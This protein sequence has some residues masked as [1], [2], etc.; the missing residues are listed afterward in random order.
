[1]A[2]SEHV[3]AICCRPEV[4]G[5]VVSGENVKTIEGYAVLDFEF[6]SFESFRDIPPKNHFV[7]A[8]ADIDDSMKRK[9]IRV[10][11]IITP[12]PFCYRNNA[13]F[14]RQQCARLMI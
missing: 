1:M 5:D 3:Y 6:A 14:G 8:E 11:H 4:A 7:T 9:R 12:T 10:S 13:H 2:Q